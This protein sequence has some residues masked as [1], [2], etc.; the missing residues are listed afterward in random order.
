[1]QNINN[2]MIWTYEVIYPFK[3][4]IIFLIMALGD[5]MVYQ[6]WWGVEHIYQ[7]KLRTSFK[8]SP[9]H[10]SNK[11]IATSKLVHTFT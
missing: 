5:V 10:L 9:F 7:Q 4:E 1:M 11:E 6:L 2:K 8:M 3:N